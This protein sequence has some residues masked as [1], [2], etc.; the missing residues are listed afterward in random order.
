MAGKNVYAI[1]MAGGRG[2]RFWPQSRLAKPKQLLKLFDDL[3]LIEHTVERLAPLAGPENTLIITNA[4]Y[5]G[6]M[7][8]LL[9]DI[10]D[11]NI[12]GEPMGRD[13]APCVALAAALVAATESGS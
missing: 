7:R 2:E 13:T 1:V 3:T 9:S 10:P 6:P 5:V 4:D 12:I 11:E 8:S